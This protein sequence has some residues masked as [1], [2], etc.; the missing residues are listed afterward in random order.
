MQCLSVT[1]GKA[2]Y[3]ETTLKA[4]YWYFCT[5]LLGL[6]LAVLCSKEV[7]MAIP[8]LMS[9]KYTGLL[10]ALID[11]PLIFGVC[12]GRSRLI[13]EWGRIAGVKF[14]LDIFLE[15]KIILALCREYSALCDEIHL[16]VT[17]R[18][19]AVLLQLGNIILQ[20]VG[21][22]LAGKALQ[23]IKGTDGYSQIPSGAAEQTSP[24]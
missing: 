20:F 17:L 4:S 21:F 14:V 7:Y 10:S 13:H 9:I 16:P 2:S 11:G 23:E 8:Y 18:D 22:Y 5:L 1:N 24:V 19:E 12:K 6:L 15:L 3:S